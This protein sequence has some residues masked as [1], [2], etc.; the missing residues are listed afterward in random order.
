MVLSASCAV[1]HDKGQRLL[2]I[3]SLVLEFN[4]KA[5]GIRELL[6]PQHH[7]L[8]YDY[9]DQALTALSA[10][11]FEWMQPCSENRKVLF[12]TS[13]RRNDITDRY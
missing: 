10:M 6:L 12:Y 8:H 13:I 1:N 11:T 5:N 3:H 7:E 9:V 2:P 4:T